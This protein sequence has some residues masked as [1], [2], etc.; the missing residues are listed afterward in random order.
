MKSQYCFAAALYCLVLA[1]SGGCAPA[2]T[3][4]FANLTP[5]Q[6]QV[7]GSKIRAEQEAVL[8]QDL[9]EA[10]AI[11]LPENVLVL[12]GGGPDGAFGCGVLNGWR[13]SPTK[14]PIFDV[15]TGVST[16]A[17]IAPFAF[18]GEER[19]DQLLRELYTH[20]R[21]D[22]VHAGAFSAGSPVAV[23]DTT[24]LKQLIARHV[25]SETLDRIAAA[26]RQGRRLYVATV[27][28]D[29]GAV[30]IWPMSRIAA[31]SSPD[32]LDR[33]RQILL[34]AAAI[35]V[36]FAPVRIDGD[37]HVDAGM[38]ETVFLRRAML[39]FT[40]AFDATRDRHAGIRPPTVWAIINRKLGVS[41][42]EIA[43]NVVDIGSRSLSLFALSLQ[44]ANIRDIAQIAA[45]HNPPFTFRY[46]AIPQVVP[47]P[48][49]NPQML[50]PMF[51]PAVMAPLYQA[52]ES[53]GKNPASWHDGP[54]QAD[55]DPA[56]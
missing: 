51:D 23:F 46:V 29:A 48:L 39:G 5:D 4:R 30:L 18:L 53:S 28:L 50:K 45:A 14:R 56:M 17:L 8:Q 7:L 55:D 27:D 31:G 33:F 42:R 13:L 2:S 43:P 15:V 12:S 44:F 10:F 9:R 37:L 41:P 3:S 6:A 40:R 49:N 52:G 54:P 22:D 1:C 38:R 25:T 26:H 16:G 11:H 24:P 20:L 34:A 47:D 32:R 35:P 19:D 21:D 36:L